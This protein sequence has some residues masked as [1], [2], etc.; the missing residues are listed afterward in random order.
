MNSED[1]GWV[2]IEKT[3]RVEVSID[4]Y[5][6]AYGGDPYGDGRSI[7]EAIEVDVEQWLEDLSEVAPVDIDIEVHVA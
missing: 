7:E 4:E 3:V 2:L 1:S 5:F 6:A